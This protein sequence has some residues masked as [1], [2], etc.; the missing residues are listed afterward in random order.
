MLDIRIVTIRH[1][2]QRY[3]TVGDWTFNRVSQGRKQLTIY[4][5]DMQD[6][7]KES[8]VAIHELVEVL[9]CSFRGITEEQVDNFDLEYEAKRTK[10]DLT[11]EPGD[12]ILAPYHKEHFFATNIERLICAEMGIDWMEYEKTVY[13]L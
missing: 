5:S 9:L 10:D 11:S 6:M 1:K 12:S 7:Y 2:D 13:S 8:L 3:P 4:V